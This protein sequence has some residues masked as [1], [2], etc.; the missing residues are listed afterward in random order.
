VA[1]AVL[2]ASRSFTYLKLGAAV[3][4]RPVD[5]VTPLA[6]RAWRGIFQGAALVWH[7]ARLRFAFLFFGATVLVTAM[8][9][10]LVVLFI[11]EVLGRGDMDLGLVLS[12]SGLGGI[13]GALAGSLLLSGRRPLR[14]VSWLM[15]GYGC[16]L[17]LFALAQHIVATLVIFCLFGIIST[18]AQIS[19]ASFLQREAPAEHRGKVF[20]WLGAFIQPLSLASVFIGSL[21]ADA[22]GVVLVLIFSGS[23]ELLVGVMGLT[24]LPRLR[25]VEALTGQGADRAGLGDGA[26]AGSA[27][28]VAQIEK[29]AGHAARAGGEKMA[30]RA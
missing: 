30:E 18:I 24:L 2:L 15:M 7:S 23:F 11:K 21:A 26:A 10:P 14:T 13:A 4:Q 22:V 3:V 27:G 8:Q 16:L 28:P 19:L 5:L 17:V 9:T 12:A 20:G 29:A 1:S 6:V 25:P